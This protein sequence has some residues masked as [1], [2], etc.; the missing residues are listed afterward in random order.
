MV[1]H[2]NRRNVGV[3]EDDL[4]AALLE[5]LDGL[6]AAVVELARLADG[7]AARTEQQ[8]LQEAAEVRVGAAG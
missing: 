7:Q 8:D 6:A 2:L 4:A 3:H 1:T 5:R